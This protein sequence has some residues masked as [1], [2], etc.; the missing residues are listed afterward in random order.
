MGGAWGFFVRIL[1]CQKGWV[2]AI[3]IRGIMF[4]VVSEDIGVGGVVF[5]EVEGFVD[6]C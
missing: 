6:G 2:C 4:E 1:K 3:C 5:G